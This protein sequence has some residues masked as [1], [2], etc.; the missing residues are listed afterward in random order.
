MFAR[1]GLSPWR[2]EKRSEFHTG[3]NL[4]QGGSPNAPHQPCTP[5]WLLPDGRAWPLS[6]DAMEQSWRSP[7][8]RQRSWAGALPCSKGSPTLPSTVS[9]QVPTRGVGALGHGWG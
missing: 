3:K 8:V 7:A 4:K 2:T 6:P 5:P 1:C 9:E